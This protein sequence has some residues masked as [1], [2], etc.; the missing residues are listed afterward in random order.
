VLLH[1]LRTAGIPYAREL[2]TGLAGRGQAAQRSSLGQLSRALEKWEL[3]WSPLTDAQLVERTAW[4][5]TLSDVCSRLLRQRLDAAP[6]V[7]LGT[8]VL[9]EMALCDL[10]ELIPSSIE[11]CDALAADSVSFPALAQAAFHLDGLLTLGSA[12]QLDVERLSE[13]A[14]RL[15]A[16]AIV[17]LPSAANCGDDATDEVQGALLALHGMVM[18]SSAVTVDIPLFWEAIDRLAESPFTHPTLRGLG[19]VLLELDGRLPNGQLSERLGYWLS[20]RDDVATNARLVA[21]LFALHRSTL[22]R[23]R[24][25][26]R[27]VT[28]FLLGLEVEQLTPLLPVLRRTLGNL[29]TPERAYLTETLAG[30]LD[31]EQGTARRVLTLS[32]VDQEILREVDGAV[33]AT[34]AHWSE[35]YGIK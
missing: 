25:I 14:N 18:R 26:I 10:V 15:S 1:R 9:F 20:A 30:M 5:T 6:R 33:A 12:R 2:E 23:N 13:L 29:S 27:A 19:L 34:L 22:V 11:R 28:D 35:H 8:A 21:G 31:L 16:R 7:D 24:P 17:A 32:S 3:Q 4:G